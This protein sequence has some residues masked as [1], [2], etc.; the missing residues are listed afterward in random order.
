MYTPT[1]MNNSRLGTQGWMSRR[2]LVLKSWSV[3]ASGL[4]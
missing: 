4:S 1:G 2:I 3:A